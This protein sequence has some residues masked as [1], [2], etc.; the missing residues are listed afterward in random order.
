MS[1]THFKLQRVTNVRR[2]SPA[3][4]LSTLASLPIFA[5]YIL[6]DIESLLFSLQLS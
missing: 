1:C 6:L 2:A 4:A 5:R 3:A